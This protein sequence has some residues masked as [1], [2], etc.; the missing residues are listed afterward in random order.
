MEEIETKTIMAEICECGRLYEDQRDQTGKTMCSACYLGCEVEM[1]KLL[2]Q[3]PVKR[4]K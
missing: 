3:M 2:W 1:L 4:T